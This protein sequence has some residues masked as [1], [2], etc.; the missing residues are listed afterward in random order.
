MRKEAEIESNIYFLVMGVGGLLKQNG[1]AKLSF[2]SDFP[3]EINNTEQLTTLSLS[4]WA[5]HSLRCKL[6]DT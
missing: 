1:Y 2:I 3:N 4:S 6:A 5:K